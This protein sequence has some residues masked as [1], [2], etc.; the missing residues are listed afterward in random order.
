MELT[1]LIIICIAVIISYIVY[2]LIA[3]SAHEVDT[4]NHHLNLQT[5]FLAKMAEK[6]G[7][8]KNEIEALLKKEVEGN[9]IRINLYIILLLLFVVLA[10]IIGSTIRS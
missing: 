8:A 10:I 7:V 6:Q 4:R 1:T 3:Q 2:Y 9:P 5:Q